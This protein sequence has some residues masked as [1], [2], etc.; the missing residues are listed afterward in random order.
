MKRIKCT[1]ETLHNVNAHDSE[2][3]LTKIHV[4][5]VLS[6]CFVSEQVVLLERLTIRGQCCVNTQVHA[7][8]LVCTGLG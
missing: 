4:C 5:G 1:A 2:S 6:F 3:V 8:K 7:V